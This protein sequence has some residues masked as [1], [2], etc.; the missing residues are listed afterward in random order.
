MSDENAKSEEPSQDGKD[1][2]EQGKDLESSEESDALD[3]KDATLEVSEEKNLEQVSADGVPS[4][5]LYLNGQGGSDDNDGSSPE[6]ALKSF[7][8][9]KNKI[10]ETIKNIFVTG[11][12]SVEGEVSL[13]GTNAKLVRHKGFNGYLLKVEKDKEATLKDIVIDGNSENNK[14]IEKSLIYVDGGT[15]NIEDR[16]VLRNNKIKD[17]KN[18]ATRGGGVS[19]IKKN[20]NKKKRGD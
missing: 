10:T 2:A 1:M 8:A 15:L 3:K 13:E 16:A 6:K 7:E 17:I 20:I 4:D 5:A 9:V 19:S 18:T 12:T 14:N 11:T